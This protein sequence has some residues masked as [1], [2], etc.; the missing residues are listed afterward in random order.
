MTVAVALSGGI[1]SLVAAWILKNRNIPVF[2]IHFITGY[3][4][5]KHGYQSKKPEEDS[6]GYDNGVHPVKRL[7]D[8]L[9]I[10]LHMA[11]CNRVFEKRI[12]DYFAETYRSGNTPNP[13]ML[14]NRVIKFG[15]VLE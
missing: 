4:S 9:G 2:G 12:V 11:D 10:P 14:C 1:D 3:E 8:R 6:S 13:C 7:A 15:E 5:A